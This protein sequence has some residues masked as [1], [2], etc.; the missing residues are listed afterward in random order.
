VPLDGIYVR[1]SFEAQ[2]FLEFLA[3]TKHSEADRVDLEVGFE[4]IYKTAYTY[5]S[6]YIW[7]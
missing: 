2:T 7:T 1:I 5:W 6:S 4:R 3:A